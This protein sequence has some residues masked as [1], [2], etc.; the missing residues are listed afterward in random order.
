MANLLTQNIGTNYKG[1]LNL[2]STINTPLDT[3]PRVITDGMGNSSILKLGTTKTEI[4]GLDALN[5]TRS[6]SVSNSLTQGIFS[7]ANDGY[8]QIGDYTSQGYSSNLVFIRASGATRATTFSQSNTDFSITN[9]NGKF[10]F[11]SGGG[12]TNNGMLT[13]KSDGGNIL[14]LRDSTNVEKTYVTST[15]SI[16]MAASSSCPDFAASLL[17]STTIYIAG[18]SFVKSPSSGVITITDQPDTGFNRLQLGGTTSSFP[19]IKRNATAIDF[20][21]ADDTAY[22][23][24][25]SSNIVATGDGTSDILKL[26]DSGGVVGIRNYVSGGSTTTIKIGRMADATIAAY[27]SHNNGSG[28]FSITQGY[29]GATIKLINGVTTLSIAGNAVN[30]LG[31]ASSLSSSITF[32]AGATSYAHSQNTYTI[33]NSGAQTGT[34]TGIFLNATETALNGMTHNLMDLQVGGTSKF[35]ISSAGA[36]TSSGTIGLFTFSSYFQFASAGGGLTSAGCYESVTAWSIDGGSTYLL[37]LKAG[38]TE[39]LTVNNVGTIAWG[40]TSSFPAIKRNGAAIDFRLADDSG[41]CDIN[42]KIATFTSSG[43]G[44]TVAS[45]LTPSGGRVAFNNG[46]IESTGLQLRLSSNGTF[47]LLLMQG[48]TEA[49][50]IDSNKNIGINATSIN[51]SAKLQVDSTTQGVLFPRMTTTQKN[52]ISSPA[53]GLVVYDSTLNKLAVYNGSAWE[54]VTSV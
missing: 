2:D 44:D 43:A 49:L 39:K 20:R 19:A 9:P 29:N 5:T 40:T 30:T 14:S 24:I 27:L 28:D 31:Y 42:G 1:L 53:T 51:S 23:P 34:A 52:A 3:T 36:I 13:I 11:S 21:L 10:N 54:T 35:K 48:G 8:V 7:I 26:A 12:I 25:N 17:R 22:A 47:P 41:Y 33:N 50:R 6:L 4:N 45:F 18:N 16:V 15:G 37:R 38:G 46:Y 32:A